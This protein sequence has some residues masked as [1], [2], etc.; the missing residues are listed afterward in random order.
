MTFENF[1]DDMGDKPTPEHTIERNDNDG[2]YEKSNCR[3]ATP[4]EQAQNR[5]S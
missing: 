2:N 1:Y 5:R 4:W 3:W